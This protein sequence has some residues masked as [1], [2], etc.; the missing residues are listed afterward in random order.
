MRKTARR[1][2]KVE[3]VTEIDGEGKFSALVSV[4]GVLDSYREVVM[5]GAFKDS[6]AALG[7]NPLPIL[8]NHQWGD[9]DAHL[10]SAVGR[11]TDE[12]LVLD[13][14]M[15]PEDANAMKVYR[16]LRQKRIREF[17]IGG[18]EW[19]EDVEQFLWDDG[20]PAWKVHRFDLVETSVVLRG[21]NAETRVLSGF[22]S[23]E[24]AIEAVEAADP[25]VEDPAPPAVEEVRVE[26]PPT[27]PAEPVT[28][29]PTDTPPAP[30]A[31]DA[32]QGADDAGAPP[33]ASK[34]TATLAAAYLA[35]TRPLGRGSS[36]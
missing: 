10:G 21:A 28:P 8:W 1:A 34:G 18:F 7:E 19:P 32:P 12:G 29:A 27:P 22:K 26:D 11:E 15:D 23:L 14:E 9:L 3:N 20:E 17:S 13:I 25:H 33:A 30:P 35:I 5:P 4:F 36:N 2:V 16:L 6:L 31:E 24:A